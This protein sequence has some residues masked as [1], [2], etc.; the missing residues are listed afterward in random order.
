MEAFPLPD[1]KAE[2][3]AA[4]FVIE[5]V[6]RFGVPGELHSDQGTNFESAV[7]AEMCRL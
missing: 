4:K 3:V 1:A 7:F 2:T 6:F 5:F